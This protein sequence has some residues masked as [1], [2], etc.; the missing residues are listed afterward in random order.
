MTSP[1]CLLYGAYGY[2]GELIAREAVLRG[3]HPILA[4]RRAEPLAPLAQELDLQYRAFDLDH[5]KTLSHELEDVDAVLHCAGP[6]VR[7][8][9]VMVDACLASGTDY[10]DIT[11]EIAVFE[12]V[13]DRDTDARGS[14]I[15]LLPGVGLDVVPSDCLAVHLAQQLPDATHLELALTSERG[16]MS[17]GTLSTM[18]EALPHAGAERVDGEIVGRPPAFA[19]REIGFSCGRRWTMTIPWGDIATAYRSTG[20]PNIRVYA[21]ASPRRIA[22]LRR[23]GPLLRLLG[24]RHLKNALQWAIRKRVTGPTAEVR[25]SAR[26]YF[27]GRVR[28][29]SGDTR[30]A[31][32]DTPE[33]YKLTAMTAVDCLQ[34]VLDRQLAAGAWTPG[35]AFGPDFITTFDGVSASW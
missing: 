17:R 4:G 15:V 30:K 31:F 26:T 9:R 6:F 3:L 12:S 34:R 10:L 2:T 18:I 14:G 8:S 13:L 27:W 32:L 19:T 33:G 5:A 11:G 35:T 22:R 23:I 16:S 25:D 28:N 24:N 20:I 7:T 29:S 21:G 1:T